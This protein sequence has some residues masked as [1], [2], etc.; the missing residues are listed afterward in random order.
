MSLVIEFIRPDGTLLR[1][2][3]VGFEFL[4]AADIPL[5]NAERP[6]RVEMG[7]NLFC[8]AI[9][10]P[11]GLQTRVRVAASKLVLEG[12][13]PWVKAQ[14]MIDGEAFE[15]TAR[16][17]VEL[18]RMSSAV[19]NP[20]LASPPPTR[21]PPIASPPRPRVPP[22]ASPPPTRLAP[23]ASPPPP[24]PPPVVNQPPPIVAVPRASP[25]KCP[26]CGGEL[27]EKQI[28]VGIRFRKF[29]A[30]LRYPMCRYTRNIQS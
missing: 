8:P 5:A 20:P 18:R 14:V 27:D 29:L 9:P 26:Q 21:L 1:H 23:V 11:D 15:L 10:L 24:R 7:G 12:A 2:V 22:I 25:L 16:V 19:A 30:C 3:D 17:S 28:M 13:S 6:I 4:D